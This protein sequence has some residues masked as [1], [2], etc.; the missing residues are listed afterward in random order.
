M[1]KAL[2]CLSLC[3]PL[4]FTACATPP[5]STD[6]ARKV[7]EDF[8]GIAAGAGL[9]PENFPLI[10]ELGVSWLR[11][12]FRWNG[13]EPA[14]EQWN[15]TYWDEYA[16]NSARAGKKLVAILG[17][18]TS[19][20]YRETPN[21]RKITAEG[22]PHYLNYVETMA[23]RYR[24]RIDAYEIWNEP[25]MMSWYGTDDE[26]IEMTRAAI[27][28]IRSID[29]EV[30]ILVG[31]YWRVPKR[32]IRKMA[33]SGVLS[34]ADGVSFH[35][36]AVKPKN[37]VKLYDS[38][39]AVLQKEEINTEIWITE[40]GYPTKGWY[41]TRVSLEK[42]PSHIIK[43]LAG[44]TARDIRVLLWYELYDYRDPDNLD[45]RWNSEDFFGIAYPNN[46]VKAGYYAFALCGKNL[47]GKEYRPELP[48]RENLPKRTVSLCFR[49]GAENVL[50]IW[51]ERG[52]SLQVTVTLPGIDQRMYDISTGSFTT[53]GEKTE[54]AI[55]KTPIFFTWTGA[56]ATVSKR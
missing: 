1:R 43:T 38:L 14:R 45:S 11:R 8:F 53:L 23:L 7:P 41:P 4:F 51:N 13:V 17:F 54:L 29:P 5:Y 47:P 22:L 37:S 46:T 25:N 30:K 52:S 40:V 34:E 9:K 10:D 36:Y 18:D 42:Y 50:I 27:Q 6:E 35:P 15:F 31:S 2:F 44:L 24:G 16:G 55:A 49:E 19:W 32:L 12:T 26:F 3:L 33:R 20:I 56:D 39:L 21:G 48:L 28:K